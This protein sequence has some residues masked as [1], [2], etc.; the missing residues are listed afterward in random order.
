MTIDKQPG[1]IPTNMN[2]NDQ[3]NERAEKQEANL[4]RPAQHLGAAPKGP[5]SSVED[6]GSDETELEVWPPTLKAEALRDKIKVIRV[7]RLIEKERFALARGEEANLEA[8]GAFEELRP[9]FPYG[10]WLPFIKSEAARFG[11]SH[12]TIQDYMRR[13]RETKDPE[14]CAK[15]A[16]CVGDD[17]KTIAE[18]LGV[19]IAEKETEAA[20][21]A[22]ARHAQQKT[23]PVFGGVAA[24]APTSNSNPACSEDVP[25]DGDTVTPASTGIVGLQ[26]DSDLTPSEPAGDIEVGPESQALPVPPP[27]LVHI[28]LSIPATWRDG[29]TN[30]M[31]SQNWKDAETEFRA[32]LRRLLVWFKYL[33]ESSAPKETDESSLRAMWPSAEIPRYEDDM[34]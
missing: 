15:S 13:F 1:Q 7:T 6:T 10:T 30:L 26:R 21:A 29:L 22:A 19:I 18:N 5:T 33:D 25:A 16:H 20:N 32:L 11:L 8:G 4:T 2:S 17:P 23:E 3:S 31:A 24:L 28:P 14:K 12:R 9:H 27:V 34:A